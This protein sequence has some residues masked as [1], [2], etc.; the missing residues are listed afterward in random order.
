MDL[1][2]RDNQQV[3]ASVIEHYIFSGISER[4]IFIKYEF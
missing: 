3:N 1:K 2:D 4:H